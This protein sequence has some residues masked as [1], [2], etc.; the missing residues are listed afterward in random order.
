VL[1]RYS[2]LTEGQAQQMRPS[3]AST[4]ASTRSRPQLAPL[5]TNDY[6]PHPE[7]LSSTTPSGRLSANSFSGRSL[8]QPDV[9]SKSPNLGYGNL[10][11]PPRM[12]STSPSAYSPTSVISGMSAISIDRPPSTARSTGSNN[13]RL[14]QSQ[15]N[16]MNSLPTPSESIAS[17]MSNPL[18]PDSRIGGS[19][20]SGANDQYTRGGADYSS[21]LNNNYN[22]G[23]GSNYADSMNGHNGQQGNDRQTSQQQQQQ[24]PFN[25]HQQYIPNSAISRSRSAEILNNTS[26]SQL[27][28]LPNPSFVTGSD[29]SGSAPNSTYGDARSNTGSRLG[30]YN[31]LGVNDDFFF[32][33]GSS[34]SPPP[35]PVPVKDTTVIIA[36]M[37]CKVFFQQHHAQ[38]KSLGTAKLKLFLSSPSNTK[39]LVVESEKEMKGDKKTF[40]ST[41]VLTDGVEKVGKTGVAIELSD[42]G[43]RTGIV[44]MLQV[45]RQFFLSFL[46]INRF[47]ILMGS[48][49]ED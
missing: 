6:I 17:E 20:Y 28:R 9:P 12:G 48:S 27:Y 46:C 15:Y 31:G 5:S 7:R 38:W 4:S 41:I 35:S 34:N 32:D 37:K 16:S 43:V 29:R 45:R 44:Y 23:N 3:S 1:L 19:E 25:P 26:S 39:Q 14:Q 36:Q 22:N 21:R 33:D 42:R 8:Q 47:E 10:G 13:D 24:Q 11:V 2:I 40:V 18:G 30:H 49:W